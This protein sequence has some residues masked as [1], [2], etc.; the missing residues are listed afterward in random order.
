MKSNKQLWLT[1]DNGK[2]KLQLPVN[3]ETLEFSNGS[4]TTSVQIQGIGEITVI[5]PPGL[6]TITL[7]AEFPAHYQ[8]YCEYVDIPAPRDAAAII[9]RWR[10]AQTPIRF[11][12]T[13]T[14]W[15]FAVTIEDFT[16]RE[17]GGDVDTLQYS[18]TLKEYRFIKTRKME[19]KTDKA[20]GKKSAAVKKSSARPKTK[21]EPKT[22]K[23][24]KGDS[25]WR[26]GQ[27]NKT[28]WQAIADLNKIKAPYTIQ[29]GQVLKLP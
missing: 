23:V 21:P 17:E 8:P 6:K 27:K 24:V 9:E 5:G 10:D 25:L 15:N 4:Q 11:F 14:P 26:I 19:Q 18:L 22:Y 13:K 16:Y 20:T 1:R 29:P 3:P 12:A 2:E 7:S 28:T